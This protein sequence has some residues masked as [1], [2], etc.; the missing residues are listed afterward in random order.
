MKKFFNVLKKLLLAILIVLIVVVGVAFIYNRVQMRKEE[1][2]WQNPPGQMVEVDGNKMH[3]YSEGKGEHTIVFMSA[4]GDPSPYN[5]FLPLCKALN[6]DFRV[7]IVERF[8]YGFSDIV[9]GERDFKTILE[10]DRAALKAAGIEGPFILCPHSISGL[11]ATLWAQNYADEVEGIVGL[12]MSIK[13]KKDMKDGETLQNILLGAAKVFNK[14][15]MLRVIENIGDSTLTEEDKMEQ[16]ITYKI[17]G[18]KNVVSENRQMDAA[19]ELIESKPL[20]SVPTVQYVAKKTAQDYP[21][22]KSGHQALAE[23]SI[24]GQYIEMD[25]GHYLYKEQPEVIID[26]IREFAEKL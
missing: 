18:N 23:A 15:G 6:K 7:V 19:C 11:E 12:D 3:I 8:G 20:P 4:W 9:D 14:S 21:L 10:N 2:Y 17:L 1:V 24:D 13:E 25:A 22:W 5:Q 16:V 26:G